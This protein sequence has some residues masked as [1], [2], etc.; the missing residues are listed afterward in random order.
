MNILLRDVCATAL[1]SSIREPRDLIVTNGK[2]VKELQM[3]KARKLFWLIF[4]CGLPVSLL[5]PID[6]GVE[7][8]PEVECGANVIII[9]FN[10]R[11]PF[12]GYVYVKVLF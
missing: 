2:C 4:G 1:S 10:T 3:R 9:N 6:N 7:G 12:E 8:D 11:N 5:I